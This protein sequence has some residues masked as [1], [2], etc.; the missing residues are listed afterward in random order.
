MK[1]RRVSNKRIKQ[2]LDEVSQGETSRE[3]HSRDIDETLVEKAAPVWGLKAV[4]ILMLKAKQQ[5]RF[6]FIWGA[7]YR[8]FFCFLMSN[9]CQLIIDS[10]VFYCIGE[11]IVL[12][13]Y[14]NK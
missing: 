6:I 4:L 11:S 2:I 9:F 7:C 13:I 8:R 14:S 10:F 5:I 12:K 1:H 3:M